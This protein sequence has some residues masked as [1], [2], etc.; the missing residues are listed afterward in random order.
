MG[1]ERGP[2][3]SECVT[4][5][6]ADAWFPNLVHVAC[7]C[8]WRGPTHDAYMPTTR[9]LIGIEANEHMAEGGKR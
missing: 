8:G 7:S 6:N 9:A 5:V 4:D 3:M 1:R 2:L